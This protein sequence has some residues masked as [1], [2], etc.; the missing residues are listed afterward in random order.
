[1]AMRQAGAYTEVCDNLDSNLDDWIRHILKS[2]I[3]IG[4]L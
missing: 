2:K 4:I 3:K 1:M